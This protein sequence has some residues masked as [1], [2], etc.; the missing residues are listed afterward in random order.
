MR[1]PGVAMPWSVYSDW[2]WWYRDN[3]HSQNDDDFDALFRAH[4]AAVYDAAGEPHPTALGVPVDG[5]SI[6]EENTQPAAEVHPTV[7]GRVSH[8]YEWHGAGV[9]RQ[10]SGQGAMHRVAR[11]AAVVLYGYSQG[12]VHLRVDPMAGSQLGSC[13][14]T[15]YGSGSLSPMARVELVQGAV[16]ETAESTGALMDVAEWSVVI[17]PDAALPLE[18]VVEARST[19]GLV[20]RLPALGRW[21]LA[22]ER[23]AERWWIV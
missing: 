14:L 11:V 16:V 17:A 6:T 5:G 2:F 21:A 10:A 20:E 8:Y 9:F 12:R 1:Y 22:T 15:L 19:A 18:L 13:T 4:C 3:F 23:A 7:D